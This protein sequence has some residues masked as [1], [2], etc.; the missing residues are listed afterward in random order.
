MKVEIY[1]LPPLGS[2]CYIV[3]DEKSGDAV[4][5]DAGYP[6]PSALRRAD[7]LGE[8]VRYL[9]FTHRHFDH[10]LGAA[11]FQR[12]TA[13]PAA[14]H[15]KDALGLS[16]ERVSMFDRFA[17][18]YDIAQESVEPAML[19]HDGDELDFGDGVIRVISTAG[20]TEGS[21]CFMIGDL[22]FTG[23]TLFCGSMGRV[24]FPTGSQ[25]QMCASLRRLARLEGNF[26][27]YAGHGEPTTLEIERKT[28]IYMK[29]ANDEA[30]CDF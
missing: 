28:N 4:I 9:L 8:R 12:A 22:L 14:I 25:E 2:N 24:D 10:V 29:R 13:A 16:D 27:V 6:E 18:C 7:E 5:I 1:Q 3:T 11:A 20:H 23:D 30:I 19:L 21:V 17:D 26:A 15:E